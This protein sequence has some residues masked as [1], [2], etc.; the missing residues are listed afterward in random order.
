MYVCKW[1][2]KAWIQAMTDSKTVLKQI[3]FLNKNNMIIW[4]LSFIIHIVLYWSGFLCPRPCPSLASIQLFSGTTLLEEVVAHNFV[5]EHL[6]MR[7]PPLSCTA[8]H[9]TKHPP[10]NLQNATLFC[11]PGSSFRFKVTPAQIPMDLPLLPS[12]CHHEYWRICRMHAAYI[13]Q[14]YIFLVQS[15]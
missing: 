11:G 5:H 7:S 3:T 10:S 6:R 8:S 4:V 14:F 15:C 13:P 9:F 1:C 2:Q 12:P